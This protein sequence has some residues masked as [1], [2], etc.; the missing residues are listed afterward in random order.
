MILSEAVE[1]VVELD[2]S[3][4]GSRR[5]SFYFYLGEIV[6]AVEVETQYGAGSVPKLTEALKARGVNGLSET[7]LY[8]A[9]GFS[10][11][12]KRDEVE[13][14]QDAGVSWRSASAICSRHLTESKRRGVLLRLSEGKIDAQRLMP[15]VTRARDFRRAPT[16]RTVQRARTRV[17]D[18]I[19]HLVQISKNAEDEEVRRAAELA[20]SE[21]RTRLARGSPGAC[22][23]GKQSS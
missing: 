7:T 16:A 21:A 10:R 8:R 4:V 3:F 20:L 13:K 1:K 12:L 6:N 2:R 23:R 19:A 15:D 22:R 5:L 14:L 18:G 17:L 11:R 9:A